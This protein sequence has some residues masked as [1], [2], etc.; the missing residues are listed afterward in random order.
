MGVSRAPL[1]I[2]TAYFVGCTLA[3]AEEACPAAPFETDVGKIAAAIAAQPLEPLHSDASGPPSGTP[4][5]ERLTD[6]AVWTSAGGLGAHSAVSLDYDA[7]RY[8]I[9]HVLEDWPSRDVYELN[10]KPSP[11]ERAKPIRNQVIR[12]VGDVTYTTT[13]AR[14]T[15]EQAREFACLANRLLAPQPEQG[16]PQQEPPQQDPPKGQ[17]PKQQ[18]SLESEPPTSSVGHGSRR[19]PSE[20]TIT[21]TGRRICDLGQFTDAHV[22][23]L[24]L[25]SKGS[26]VTNSSHLPCDTQRDLRD[27]MREVI[28]EPIDEV[29]EPNT[30]GTADGPG[31]RALFS[32]PQGLAMDREG[33]VYVADSG[34]HTIREHPQRAAPYRHALKVQ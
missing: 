1:L 29:L 5:S 20:F 13:A 17:P 4:E 11:P 2:V 18:P 32:S 33:I 10:V 19:L 9:V 27:R 15:P 12:Q 25:L 30:M 7:K 31:N 22:E 21:V 3:S 34:N 26:V 28:S 14:P 23:G 24:E 8:L 6:G 16:P